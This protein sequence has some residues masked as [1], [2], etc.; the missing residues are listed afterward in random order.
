MNSR[1]VQTPA[2]ASPL[3]VA[4][5]RGLKRRAAS[6]ES[7]ASEASYLVAYLII[8]RLDRRLPKIAEQVRKDT[9]VTQDTCIQTRK[10]HGL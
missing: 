8:D 9:I 3:V 5:D 6:L 4:G 7:G 2:T 10:L 1:P